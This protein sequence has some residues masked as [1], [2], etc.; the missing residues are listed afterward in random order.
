M[1]KR[2]SLFNLFLKLGLSTNQ[3]FSENVHQADL[4]ML[5]L[6]VVT[7]GVIT[8]GVVTAGV[9]TAGVVTA[10]VLVVLSASFTS[11]TETGPTLT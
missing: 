5:A 9:V 11:Q 10:R 1:I 8:A 7:A 6:R 2:V 4:S 3:L